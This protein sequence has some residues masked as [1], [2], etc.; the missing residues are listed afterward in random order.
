MMSFKK[1]MVHK[2]LQCT[3]CDWRDED[4]TKTGYRASKHHR[5]TGHKITGEYGYAVEWSE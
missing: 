4:Y 3:E 2:I 1:W 5:E